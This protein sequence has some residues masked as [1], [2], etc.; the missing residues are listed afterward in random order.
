MTV[1]SADDV[2]FVPERLFKLKSRK[3]IVPNQAV[4]VVRDFCE[5]PACGSD[6]T[7]V[8]VKDAVYVNRDVLWTDERD[9]GHEYVDQKGVRRVTRPSAI[10]RASAHECSDCGARLRIHVEEKALGQISE[11][12]LPDNPEK[13][14]YHFVEMEDGG[15]VVVNP[16]QVF[17]S[18]E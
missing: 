7:D 5:C 3:G 17:I 14:A 11:A 4:F 13:A 16:M 18:E 9:G 2:S 8:D 12:Q 6:L 1:L 15:Y 10:D